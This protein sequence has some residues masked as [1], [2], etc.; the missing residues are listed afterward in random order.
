VAFLNRDFTLKKYN[1]LLDAFKK[2][3][4]NFQTLEDFVL[5]PLP[6]VVILRHDVDSWPLNALQIAELENTL[7]IK[8]TYYFRKS[9]LSFKES[10]VKKIVEYE[11][12]IGYHYEDLS[13]TNGNYEK[14]I[15]RF[16]ENLSFFRNYYPVTTISMHGRPLSKYDSKDLWEKYDY[17]SYGLLAEPY[18][19]IDFNEILY[20]TDTGNR[21]DGDKY[22]IRDY[23][24]SKYSY[25]IHNTDEMIK[26]I[27]QALLPDRIMLNAHPARW[28][29][30]IIKWC[31][32]YYLLTKPKYQV[33]KW[34]KKL[35]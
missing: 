23:V 5:S 7:G 13:V 24:R 8:A 35:R 9:P 18:L 26:H 12:E 16:I 15:K 11:H 22:S 1:E 25:G 31:I 34:I 29:D 20:L 30:N 6:K 28:N 19:D 10:I 3:G 32:R 4:Y 2:A 27:H 21:W 17:H 14:A 33:K